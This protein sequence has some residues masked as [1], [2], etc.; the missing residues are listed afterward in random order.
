MILKSVR[1]LIF[2]GALADLLLRLCTP[3]P[4]HV[5]ANDDPCGQENCPMITVQPRG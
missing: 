4:P 3:T 1:V 5:F 2:S